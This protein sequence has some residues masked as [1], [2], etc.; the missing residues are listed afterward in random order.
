MESIR[1][2]QNGLEDDGTPHLEVCPLTNRQSAQCELRDEHMPLLNAAM[3]GINP[4]LMLKVADD[5][6]VTVKL[7][8]KTWPPEPGV[9]IVTAY[10]PSGKPGIEPWMFVSFQTESGAAVVPMKTWVP[11]PA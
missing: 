6:A 10:V 1:Y 7:P 11:A 2:I 5:S 3:M 8:A 4:A 9:E